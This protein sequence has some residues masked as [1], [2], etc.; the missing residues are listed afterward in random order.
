[1]NEYKQLRRQAQ[2]LEKAKT[3]TLKTI[4]PLG[5]LCWMEQENGKIILMQKYCLSWYSEKP[6]NIGLGFLSNR[7]K[8][9]E[10]LE[11]PT[12]KTGEAE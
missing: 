10:W 5:G 12:F 8:T 2:K 7:H 1:M 11:V 4:E 6:Q 9:F 3:W